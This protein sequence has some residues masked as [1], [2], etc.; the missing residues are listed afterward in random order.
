MI[1]YLEVSVLI[2]DPFHFGEWVRYAKR[3]N[4]IYASWLDRTNI[5]PSL[6]NPYLDRLIK[7]LNSSGFYVI[8]GYPRGKVIVK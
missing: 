6:S 5:A 7:A 1:Q 3:V 2:N 4:A 8:G